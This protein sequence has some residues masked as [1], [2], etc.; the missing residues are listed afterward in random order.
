MR[1]SEVIETELEEKLAEIDDLE[2]RLEDIEYLLES[3]REEYKALEAEYS[4]KIDEEVFA[5]E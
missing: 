3:A 2:N 5:D 1:T 4:D